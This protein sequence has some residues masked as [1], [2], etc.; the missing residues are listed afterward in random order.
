MDTS[1][2]T[3]QM[4]QAEDLLEA[5]KEIALTNPAFSLQ[6]VLLCL[7]ALELERVGDIL[8]ERLNGE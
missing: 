3:V 6:S 2:P 1:H 4:A 8:A 5:C 7:I